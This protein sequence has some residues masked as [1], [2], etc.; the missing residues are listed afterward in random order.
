V[1]PG[2]SGWAQVAGSRGLSTRDGYLLDLW[3]VR[4]RS[5]SLD[6]RIA[7]RTPL[8]I[9]FGVECP[10]GERERCLADMFVAGPLYIGDPSSR[11]EG[12]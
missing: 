6:L 8:Y 3:Y 5:P 10:R 1:P 2:I 12:T 7:A 11:G 9:L 4:H